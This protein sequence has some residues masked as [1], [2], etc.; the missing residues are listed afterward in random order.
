M[1]RKI[2]EKLIYKDNWLEFYQDKVQFT[3]E[4]E[5]T[6][7]YAKRRDGVGVTVV[8]ENGKILLHKEHRYVI[9][10]FS[11]EIQGGGID[12]GESVVEAAARELR[13]E[14]GLAVNP[15]SLRALGSFYPLNSFNTEKVSLFMI[16]VEDEKINENSIEKGEHLEA[17]Q[18][19]TFE[20]IYRMI[21]SGQINDALTANAVQ[22]A[23]RE[24]NSFK[25]MKNFD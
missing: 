22:L 17:H 14:A 11:W 19:F 3:D 24:F 4:S 18:F 12:E 10:D 8:S 20:E 6:Y 15:K 13:E 21:E 1:L 7:A 25:K 5:G 16:V 2:K 9:D 23:M